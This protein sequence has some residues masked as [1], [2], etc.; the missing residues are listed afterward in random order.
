MIQLRCEST[1]RLCTCLDAIK[2][3]TVELNKIEF[4][5]LLLLCDF[6]SGTL[7]L[8]AFIFPYLNDLQNDNFPTEWAVNIVVILI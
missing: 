8:C 2:P 5:L 4:S 6:G 7:P 3:N 1:D